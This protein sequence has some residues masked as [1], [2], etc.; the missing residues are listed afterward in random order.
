MQILL[1]VSNNANGKVDSKFVN[2]VG[3]SSS[4]LEQ[5]KNYITSLEQAHSSESFS[6]LNAQVP[7]DYV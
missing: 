6:N 4:V 7:V 2:F 5:V 1:R 3:D